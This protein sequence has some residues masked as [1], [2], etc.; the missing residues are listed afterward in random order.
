MLL[1]YGGYCP[2][3]NGCS[4]ITI[5]LQHLNSQ[6]LRETHHTPS[7]FQIACQI[8]PNT[9][10]S[11]LD[12]A[13]G[14]HAILL[15]KESQ[16]MT[17][18]ITEWERYMYLQLRQGFLASTDAYTRRYDEIIKPIPCKAKIVDDTLLY[19]TNIEKIFFHVWGII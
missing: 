10:K 8:P 9:K 16:P 19:H 1:N 18:F 13:G 14:F 11:L 6:C 2:K 15:D 7:L 12:A 4:R 17:T 5:D 3:K